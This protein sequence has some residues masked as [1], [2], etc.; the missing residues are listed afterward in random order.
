MHVVASAFYGAEGCGEVFVRREQ[1]NRVMRLW[2]T[3]QKSSMHCLYDFRED[4]VIVVL[5]LSISVNSMGGEIK[6]N[7]NL[8]KTKRS[9]CLLTGLKTTVEVSVLGRVVY[10][11]FA[12]RAR[13]VAEVLRE[14]SLLDK[15]SL[16]SEVIIVKDHTL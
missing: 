14:I 10:S 6:R 2:W 9:I 3:A 12:F 5:C 16:D 11:Q 4:K 7:T 8:S 15:P 13:R 1:V